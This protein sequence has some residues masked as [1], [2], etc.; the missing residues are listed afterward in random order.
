[1][2]I[3]LPPR[4]GSTRS[5]QENPD[6]QFRHAIDAAGVD[7]LR[8]YHSTFLVAPRVLPVECETVR[9]LDPVGV[10]LLWLLCQELDESVG[11]RVVLIGLDQDLRQKIRS[12]PLHESLATSDELFND[13]FGSSLPSQR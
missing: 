1:M 12:H 3:S 4:A 9:V 10:A 8:Q 2:T 7:R 13:P 11:T 6:F 5:L